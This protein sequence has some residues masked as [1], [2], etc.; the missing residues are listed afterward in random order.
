METKNK[1]YT[2]FR[3]IGN[4]DPDVISARLGIVP[5]DCWKTGDRRR[6][7]SLYDFSS[8]TCGRCDDYDVY[9][10]NQMRK[11][12]SC[13]LDKTGILN[14]FRNDFD[15]RYVLEVVPKIHVNDINLFLALSLDVIDF[16]HAT[17]TEINIDMYIYSSDDEE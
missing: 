8:W 11:T 5:D 6:N 16:C 10:E 4:F 14:Q 13:L 15:V 12:I 2:Y 9:V 7:G 17:R 1:C 3:I